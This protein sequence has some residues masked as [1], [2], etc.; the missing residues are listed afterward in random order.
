[1]FCVECGKDGPIFKEGVCIN[2]Y[3][4]THSFT[5]GPNIIDIPICTHCNSY[6]YKNTWTS[7]LFNDVIIRIIKNSYTISKDLKKPDINTKC[8]EQKDRLQCRIIISGFIDDHEVSEEHDVLV[9]LKK[10]V[11]DVCSKRFGGYHEAVL[12]IRAD[13]RKLDKEELNNIILSVEGLVE[14]LQAKGNRGLFI[15]DMGEE[16]GGFDFF[17]SD[18]GAAL[19]IA[20]KIQDQY[21]GEI[22]QSSKNVGMKDSKQ[23]YKMTYLLRIP[24][25]KKGD[26]IKINNS[27]YQIITIQKNS[28]KIQN[29][30]NWEDK[31][32][33]LNQIKNFNIVGGNELVKEMI[34]V[35]QTNNEVQLMDPKNYQI[36]TIKKPKKTNIKTDMV[37][38]VIL[39]NKIFLLYK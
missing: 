17:I 8:E 32:V 21:G 12:Q 29:L 31:I 3:L 19:T 39:N 30:S 16:H 33:D 37:K 18:K 14:N 4:K 7:E 13:N 6:K 26:Y 28:I 24:S 11:C 2:C 5:K 38:V 10:T 1:M 9:R 15:T 25:Y 22:K 36:F 27:H 34:L 20:K 35:S 23:I